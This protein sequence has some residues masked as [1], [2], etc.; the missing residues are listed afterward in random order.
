MVPKKELIA[1]G[2]PLVDLKN[3]GNLKGGMLVAIAC[4]AGVTLGKVAGTTPGL[5]AFLGFDDELGFPASAVLPIMLAVTRGL[6][7]MFQK[8]QHISCAAPA[9]GHRCETWLQSLPH[10][11]HRTDVV[12]ESAVDPSRRG[13]KG[14]RQDYLRNTSCCHP[15]EA[16][17]TVGRTSTSRPWRRGGQK[18]NVTGG[19][20]NPYCAVKLT[21]VGVAVRTPVMCEN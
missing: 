21:Q 9:G 7:C 15:F 20:A 18:C 3:V 2:K 1:N 4:Y 19:T 17:L 13:N 11:R 12:G 5:R 10:E 14:I 16:R 8:G 6:S